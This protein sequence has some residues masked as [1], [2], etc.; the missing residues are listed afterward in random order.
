MRNHSSFID[1]YT[2][3]E[4]LKKNNTKN[5]RQPT[6][7]MLT[8]NSSLDLVRSETFLGKNLT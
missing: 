4:Y 5:G 7:I 3:T 8:P 1:I 2:H 6:F